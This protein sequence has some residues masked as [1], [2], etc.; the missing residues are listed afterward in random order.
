MKIKDFLKNEIKE[1]IKYKF[2]SIGLKIIEEL[3]EAEEI[4]EDELINKL[5]VPSYYLRK[6]LFKLNENR[7]KK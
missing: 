1:A 7:I 3:T 5:N 6:V 4:S 2:G